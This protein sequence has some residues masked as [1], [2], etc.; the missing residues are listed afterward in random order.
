MYRMLALA[1]SILTTAR[2]VYFQMLGWESP[3][4]WAEVCAVIGAVLLF[5]IGT[6]RI[7]Q[8][9]QMLGVGMLGGL[10]LLVHELPFVSRLLFGFIPEGR[11]MLELV[12][13]IPMLLACALLYFA[14]RGMISERVD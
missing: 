10:L 14:L 11:P 8:H 13:A 5:W 6:Q 1:A 7:K 4:W 3:W 9:S 12:A 2:I